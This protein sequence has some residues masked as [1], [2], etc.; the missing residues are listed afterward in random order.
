MKSSG[1]IMQNIQADLCLQNIKRLI[2]SMLKSWIIF[3][4]YISPK[5]FT[6]SKYSRQYIFFSTNQLSFNF[7]TFIHVFFSI[8]KSLYKYFFVFLNVKNRD[9][10]LIYSQCHYLGSIFKLFKY[11]E[12]FLQLNPSEGTG[13]LRASP[14]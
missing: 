9:D 2:L 5:H 13:F 10:I 1:R 3:K 6:S 8:Q 4:A 14:G 12:K 11:F 7:F